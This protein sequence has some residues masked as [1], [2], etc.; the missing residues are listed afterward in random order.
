M[1]ESAQAAASPENV[2][3]LLQTRLRMD[4]PEEGQ[5]MMK[6][7]SAML[8]ELEGMVRSGGNLYA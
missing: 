1:A 5:L 7:P 4:M 2:V 8:A 3:L 6:D